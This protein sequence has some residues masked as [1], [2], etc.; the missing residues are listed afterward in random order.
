MQRNKRITYMLKH[1]KS[2]ITNASTFIGIPN[3]GAA[4]NTNA[5]ALQDQLML[6]RKGKKLDIAYKDQLD[7]CF[8][9]MDTNYDF[10]DLVCGGDVKK[11]DKS[12]LNSRKNTKPRTKRPKT[13]TAAHWVQ[14]LTPNQLTLMTTRDET[15]RMTAVI[16]SSEDDFKVEMTQS[17]RIKISFGDKFACIDFSTAAKIILKYL[18][19]GK[20]VDAFLIKANANGLAVPRKM[21]KISP[22][23][24]G[25]YKPVIPQ[26]PLDESIETE[27]IPV[28]PSDKVSS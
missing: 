13:D 9:M 17:N 3:D 8:G 1:G 24:D 4:I 21:K 27:Q 6:Q 20:A 19:G 25:N 28:Q 2:L 5:L 22:N 15:S 7:V 18:E 23:I 16:F 10:V 11:N 12:G 26:K 14:D